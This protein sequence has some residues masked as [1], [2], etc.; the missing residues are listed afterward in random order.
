VGTDLLNDRIAGHFQAS[1][2]K[3]ERIDS[4]SL[5][6]RERAGYERYRRAVNEGRL[7][8]AAPL[9]QAL[10]LNPELRRALKE[11]RVMVLFQDAL[12]NWEGDARGWHKTKGNL[13]G[14]AGAKRSYGDVLVLDSALAASPL[15][16]AGILSHEVGHVIWREDRANRKPLPRDVELA[17]RSTISTEENW[18]DYFAGKQLAR[19]GYRRASRHANAGRAGWGRW[20]AFDD[21]LR[22]K[23]GLYEDGR[24]L[25]ER[26]ERAARRRSERQGRSEPRGRGPV[27]VSGYTRADGTPVTGHYRSRPND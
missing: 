14:P 3:G 27:W 21:V 22:Y 6:R 9:K 16:L 12:P 20:K 17:D 11:R 25:I 2:K 18:C 8:G 26:R 19:M 5:A 23:A 10:A 13:R 15:A 24:P 1:R 7:P 4:E